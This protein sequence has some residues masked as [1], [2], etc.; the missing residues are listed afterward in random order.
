MNYSSSIAFAVA[1][2]LF[3]LPFVEIKC[4]ST[5]L[6]KAKGIEL[7]TGFTVKDDKDKNSDDAL[8]VNDNSNEKQEPNSFAIAAFVLG[9]L[10]LVLSF[11]NF[12]TRPL[13]STLTGVLAAICLIALLIQIKSDVGKWSMTGKTD[14]HNDLFKDMARTIKI[15]AEFMAWY[16]LS[17]ISFLVAAFFSYRRKP[18]VISG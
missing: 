3:L 17:V 8:A 10:G 6:Y 1:L 13:I 15:T 12:K 18:L 11:M 4:N 14:P 16:Y 5:S 9:I 7:V 2:L